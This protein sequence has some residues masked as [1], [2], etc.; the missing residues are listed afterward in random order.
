RGL[1]HTLEQIEAQLSKVV[2]VRRVQDVTRDP[3]G[4]ER[5]LALLKVAGSDTTLAEARAAAETHGARTIDAS[6]GAM[7]F[8]VTDTS[9]RIDA[10]VERMRPLG[11]VE[12]SRTGVLSI[13]KGVE[14]L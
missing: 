12:V 7:V 3:N 1:P 13:E 4:V 5:E 11:F 9:L 10:F 6:G 8:E 2:A 14:G